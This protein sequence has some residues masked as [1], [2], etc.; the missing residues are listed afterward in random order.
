MKMVD[1]KGSHQLSVIDR[2]KI[3]L[4]GVVHVE[5]FDDDAVILE[6][7]LG[8]LVI[9]GHKLFV[10]Q[11]DVQQGNL[12]IEGIVTNIQYYDENKG[13]KGK[14]KGFFERLLK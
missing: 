7:K 13:M 2:Q 10:N 3:Q 4:T 8:G 11:L 6:T 12:S 14:S 9:K 5:S 1:S